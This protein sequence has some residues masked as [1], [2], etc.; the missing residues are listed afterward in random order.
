MVPS[1]APRALRRRL[2]LLLVVAGDVVAAERPVAGRPEAGEPD[3]LAGDLDQVVDVLAR[4]P[5]ERVVVDRQVGGEAPPV[6]LRPHDPRRR[7]R[8]PGLH[9][10]APQVRRPGLA[11]LGEVEEVLLEREEGEE[12][13]GVGRRDVALAD[14]DLAA[15]LAQRRHEHLPGDAV[16]LAV[17]P[18]VELG[19]AH[20]D[21]RHV[22]DGRGPLAADE[23]L[24]DHL[25]GHAIHE[26]GRLVGDR[27]RDARDLA[28]RDGRFLGGLVGGL[29][30]L[31]DAV[32]RRLLLGP[33][34]G[35]FRPRFHGSSWYAVV[36]FSP[37]LGR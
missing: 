19:P 3:A 29:P 34:Q 9:L 12:R 24:L 37:I 16:G 11:V 20:V 28:G 23:H 22:A 27:E 30:A 2:D 21:E 25:V 33:L 14:L 5:L 31:V 8:A 17:R 13:G 4:Q 6:E 10:P 1:R 18:D 26:Q 15:G 36:Y 7:R 32:R 35:L